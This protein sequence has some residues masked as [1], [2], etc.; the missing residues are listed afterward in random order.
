[1]TSTEDLVSSVDPK[2]AMNKQ[3]SL[4]DR[5]YSTIGIDDV[6]LDPPPSWLLPASYLAPSP[7]P[8]STNIRF[9]TWEIVGSIKSCADD[10]KVQEIASR[11]RTPKLPGDFDLIA[12]L[13]AAP[14]SATLTPPAEGEISTPCERET[15]EFHDPVHVPPNVRRIRRKNRG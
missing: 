15:K 14:S 6:F 12:D 7:G 2:G 13:A 5:H 11:K 9:Q 1:M 3:A 10:F 4:L 8:S